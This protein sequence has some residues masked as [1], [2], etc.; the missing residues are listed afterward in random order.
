MQLLDHISITVSDLRAARHFYD[1]VMAALGCEKIY[2]SQDALGYGERCSALDAD[3]TYC[4]VY[5]SHPAIPD[6]RRHWC[7]KA[8]TRA[9]VL[10][11]HAAA[12]AHGGVCDGPPG[13]RAHYHAAYYSAFVRD[14]HGNKLEAVC[15]LVA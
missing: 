7:F 6:A 8:K 14:P 15:H 2:D 13:L 12:L 1:A 11:F 5:A 4:S 9:Q 10:A 3:H